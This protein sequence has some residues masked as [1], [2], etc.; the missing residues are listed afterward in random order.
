MFEMFGRR[1]DPVAVEKR[2]LVFS[3][4]RLDV[5]AALGEVLKPEST[6]G[7]L[8]TALEGL[9]SKTGHKV[10]TIHDQKLL[11]YRME[12]VEGGGDG[13]GHCWIV[14]PLAL[15]ESIST[16]RSLLCILFSF[17]LIFQ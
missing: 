5:A 12:G 13:K 7:D 9:Y 16:S 3:G 17:I 10:T 2:P 8:K 4:V 11:S 14:F 15:A 1:A 6:L